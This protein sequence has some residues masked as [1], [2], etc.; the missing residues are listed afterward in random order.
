MVLQPESGSPDFSLPVFGLLEE[1]LVL[2]ECTV[3]EWGPLL[4]APAPLRWGV[5]VPEPASRRGPPVCCRPA[6]SAAQ[7][8]AAGQLSGQRGTGQ[9][10]TCERHAGERAVG[11]WRAPSAGKQ[12]EAPELPG[13]ASSSN[14]CQQRLYGWTLAGAEGSWKAVRAHRKLFTGPGLRCWVTPDA[15]RENP[16]SAPLE[17][18][19]T[20]RGPASQLDGRLAGGSP[21]RWKLQRDPTM[22]WL[23][24]LS[25]SRAENFHLWIPMPGPIPGSWQARG[26]RCLRKRKDQVW[27]GTP[28]SPGRRCRLFSGSGKTL[29]PLWIWIPHLGNAGKSTF[30]RVTIRSKRAI[31]VPKALCRRAIPAQAD[32]AAA[33]GLRHP[34]PTGAGG[35]GEGRSGRLAVGREPETLLRLGPGWWLIRSFA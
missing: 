21:G 7:A 33:C 9:E 25:V 2:F 29:R 3:R 10:E 27:N 19:K 15:S 20:G 11:D 23:L 12:R 24:C 34:S 18:M 1:R 35:A 4:C 6:G 14:L 8:F 22:A 17:V 32:S 28:G 13:F 16:S 5:T 31:T 30:N 26:G